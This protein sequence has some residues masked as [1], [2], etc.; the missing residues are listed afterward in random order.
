[1]TDDQQR[2]KAASEAFDDAIRGRRDVLDRRVP[3]EAGPEDPPERVDLDQGARG[4]RRGS[5]RPQPTLDGLMRA[6]R[7][8]RREDRSAL[9]HG[10]DAAR[11]ADR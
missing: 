4:G 8:M 6:E 3:P 11:D 9:A 2:S 1:M 5:P 7:Q 10:Y